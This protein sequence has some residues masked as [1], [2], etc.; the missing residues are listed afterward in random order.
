[1]EECLIHNLI[2]SINTNY[3]SVFLFYIFLFALPQFM[4]QFLHH[5]LANR[6]PPHLTKNWGRNKAQEVTHRQKFRWQVTTVVDP[7][8]HGYEPLHRRLI[9]HTGVVETSVQ[10]DDGERQHITG[11][12]NKPEGNRIYVDVMNHQLKHQTNFMQ[13]RTH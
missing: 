11:V 5:K 9:L 10:H 3:K 1:M 12:C 7:P 2:Q 4:K 13:Q 8:V 6:P